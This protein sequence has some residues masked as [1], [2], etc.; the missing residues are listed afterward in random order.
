MA[1]AQVGPTAGCVITDQ[2][3]ALKKG[4]RFWHENA[5]VFSDGQLSEVKDI[6]LAKVMCEVMEGMQRVS[7]NPFVRANQNFGGKRN[8]V[9][10]CA[11]LG[12][13]DFSPWKERSS[14]DNAT[15]APTT[16][17]TTQASSTIPGETTTKP[18][19]PTV[20]TST[21]AHS[22]IACRR[23]GKTRDSIIECGAGQWTNAHLRTLHQIMKDTGFIPIRGKRATIMRI[24]KHKVK[25]IS[26]AGSQDISSTENLKDVLGELGH[27]VLELDISDTGLTEFTTD[28]ISGNPKLGNIDMAGTA[29]SISMD[30]FVELTE[31]LKK[32]NK[33]IHFG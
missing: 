18:P 6:G 27:E 23:V 16:S 2:F 9:R 30:L 5:G 24:A 15:P 29:I 11:Q 4:D 25:R 14:T 7:E 10:T 26:F 33:F 20:D 22:L 19:R 31:R 13:I 8:E 32:H 3:I 1:G 17:T 28:I 12:K 21:V